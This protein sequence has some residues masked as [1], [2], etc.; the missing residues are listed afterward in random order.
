MKR[1]AMILCAILAVP[2][3]ATAEAPSTRPAETAGLK[4]RLNRLEQQ[5]HL[6]RARMGELEKRL[7]TLEQAPPR[8]E[9]S[10]ADVKFTEADIR[11]S[12]QAV[13]PHLQR[14]W[15]K[16]FGKLPRIVVGS[17]KAATRALAEDMVVQIRKDHPQLSDE[18]ARKAAYDQAGKMLGRTLGK[19]GVKARLLALLP[20]NLT[21]MLDRH[22]IDPKHARD[23]LTILIAHELTHALQA[24]LVDVIDRIVEI[25]TP[26]ARA[27]YGAVVEGQCM[28]AQQAV[29]KALK[30]HEANDLYNRTFVIGRLPTH[31]FLPAAVIRQEFTYVTGQEFVEALYRAQGPEAVWAAL[32]DDPPASTRQVAHPRRYLD[33]SRPQP[34]LLPALQDFAE[35]FE[36]T[37]W[38]VGQQDLPEL[39]L[40][41]LLGQTGTADLS[42]LTEPLLASAVAYARKGS[43]KVQ[44]SVFRLEEPDDSKA[45]LNA[46]NRHTTRTINRLRK[47]SNDK[48][49][50]FKTGRFAPLADDDAKVYRIVLA[51]EDNKQSMNKW[52]V[53]VARGAV[54]AELSSENVT[55]PPDEVKQLLL[56]VLNRLETPA[57][58]APESAPAE[59]LPA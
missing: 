27:A 2:A 48:V 15:G 50:T 51:E 29:A 13:V 12:V 56:D 36:N 59:E 30:L 38:R 1:Y 54:L 42:S 45:L 26:D 4:K 47:I 18:Q 53:R 9:T 20:E 5:N 3:L 25:D 19:Y 6:L 32:T 31:G 14:I 49:Q 17:K 24:E 39:A 21:E 46:F 35:H 58:S 7:E 33:R 10:N 43:Q 8:T 22:K 23:I 52:I 34:D 55:L 41:S 28:F 16:K 11:R 57:T 40:R 44:I 37:G